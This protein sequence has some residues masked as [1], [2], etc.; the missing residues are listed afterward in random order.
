MMYLKTVIKKSLN[1]FLTIRLYFC[2]NALG[3]L[4]DLLT[5]AKV[6]PILKSVDKLSV[7]YYRSVSVIVVLQAISIIL[8]GLWFSRI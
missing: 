5:I 8:D 1:P 4:P 6:V 7:N 3:V 2:N